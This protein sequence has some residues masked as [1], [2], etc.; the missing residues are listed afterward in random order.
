MKRAFWIML[1]VAV[2]SSA[3]ALRDDPRTAWTHPGAALVMP[4]DSTDG[5]VSY[6]TAHNLGSSKVSSHWSF[7]DEDGATL[8]ETFVCLTA[9]DT[10]IVDPTAL[11]SIGPDNK[12]IGSVSSLAGKRGIASV[13]AF[14]SDSN[15]T[16][17][18]SAGAPQIAD[19]ALT[20][21]FSVAEL[22]QDSSYGGNAATFGIQN[23]IVALP[24]RE[25]DHIDLESWAPSKVTK[26]QVI[27]IALREQAGSIPGELGPQGQGVLRANLGFYG[28]LS[29]LVSLAPVQLESAF[30]GDVRQLAGSQQLDT[31]GVFRLDGFSPPV[32]AEETGS[33][34]FLYGLHGWAFHAF[35]QMAW[36]SY[37]LVPATPTPTPAGTPTSTAPTP[38]AKPIP[39]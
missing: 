3:Y 20:G 8:A 6:L 19:N 37:E 4:F 14:K 30:F 27:L 23:G 36:G 11:Q 1:A 16:P 33:R 5:H 35:A 38:T 22:E 21:S 18:S 13:T 31:S 7:W 28:N 10:V 26:S 29:T 2:A 12:G 15:C 34:T 25:L 39:S 9:N 24:T 17:P 32:G